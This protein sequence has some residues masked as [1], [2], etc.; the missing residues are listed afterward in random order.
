LQAISAIEV[1]PG[2]KKASLLRVHHHSG[3]RLSVEEVGVVDA[4]EAA[5]FCAR[6]GQMREQRAVVQLA[7]DFS[8]SARSGLLSLLLL[9][10]VACFGGLAHLV[11]A[12]AAA[13]SATLCAMASRVHL[14]GS[15]FRLAASPESVA[16]WTRGQLVPRRIEGY[17]DAPSPD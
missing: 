17:R 9:V 6:A 16:A 7:D 13:A 2:R 5:K 4:H 3:T 10:P 14:S 1:W 12:A 8:A 11:F 15:T